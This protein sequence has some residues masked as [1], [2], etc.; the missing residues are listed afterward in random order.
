MSRIE[1]LRADGRASQPLAHDA[2]VVDDV[3]A[4][5]A[6]AAVTL[7]RYPDREFTELREGLAAYLEDKAINRF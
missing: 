6:R 2:P 7:N 4:S 3:A 5:V 1:V